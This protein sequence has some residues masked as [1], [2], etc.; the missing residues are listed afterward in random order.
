MSQEQHARPGF[1]AGVREQAMAGQPGSLLRA[2]RRLPAQYARLCAEGLRNT[3][4]RLGLARTFGPQGMIDDQG[5][6]DASIEPR[7][8]GQQMQQ[9]G[10]IPATRQ[11]KRQ[12][13]GRAECPAFVQ[14][15]WNVQ[16]QQP[17]RAASRRALRRDSSSAWGNS[18]SKLSST[19]QAS[20]S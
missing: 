14:E 1:T 13:A 2:R 11:A 15:G 18:A 17:A 3:G 8:I 20:A 19:L 10:G 9:G 6:Q 7:E 4:R 16:A 5:M 12:R